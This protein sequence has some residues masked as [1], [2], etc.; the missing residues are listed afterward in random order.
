MKFNNKYCFYLLIRMFNVYKKKRLKNLFQEPDVQKNL[1][2][3]K[4]NKIESS[5]T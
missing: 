3:S 1:N 4:N 2:L 5:I